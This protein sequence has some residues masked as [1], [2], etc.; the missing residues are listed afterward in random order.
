[1]PLAVPALAPAGCLTAYEEFFALA[2]R[3]PVLIDPI[4][5]ATFTIPAPRLVALQGSPRPPPT[6][7][8][9]GTG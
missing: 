9:E 6:T 5:N 7:G 3:G 2:R 4:A 8:T 1:M